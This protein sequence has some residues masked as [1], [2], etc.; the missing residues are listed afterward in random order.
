MNDDD[1]DEEYQVYNGSDDESDDGMLIDAT[2]ASNTAPNG[3]NIQR[4]LKN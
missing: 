2:P 1:E 3:V 4:Q